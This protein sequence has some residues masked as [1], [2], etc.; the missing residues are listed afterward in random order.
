MFIV[1]IFEKYLPGRN[2]ACYMEYPDLSV[3][4]WHNVREL[5]TFCELP[6]ALSLLVLTLAHHVGTISFAGNLHH[7]GLLSQLW[8]TGQT[9][10]LKVTHCVAPLVSTDKINPPQTE[11]LYVLMLLHGVSSVI[12]PNAGPCMWYVYATFQVHFL[13]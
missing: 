1:F 6:S 5:Q 2:L 9:V 11:P 8:P 4:A 10:I 13:T 7:P 3:N 12:P